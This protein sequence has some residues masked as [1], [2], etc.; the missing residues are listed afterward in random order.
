VNCFT[1]FENFN[2]VIR[3]LLGPLPRRVTT[4][5]G[6][7][8]RRCTSQSEEGT[9]VAFHATGGSSSRPLNPRRRT[10][11]SC[12]WYG[13]FLNEMVH[14]AICES[15]LFFAEHTLKTI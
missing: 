9:E 2:L 6:S 8:P 1:F 5:G 4:F 14:T 15:L 13:C 10:K 7:R 11:S 3:K 12:F